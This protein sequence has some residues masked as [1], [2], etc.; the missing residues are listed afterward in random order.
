MK[1]I[2]KL[3]SKKDEPNV[4]NRLC[5][6]WTYLQRYG[7]TKISKEFICIKDGLLRLKWNLQEVSNGKLITHH[8]ELGIKA[9]LL[10]CNSWQKICF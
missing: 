5:F 9:M 3:L 2:L 7:T 6:I 4:I 8:T 1:S 10:I